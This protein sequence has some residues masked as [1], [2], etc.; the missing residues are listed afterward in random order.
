MD[1]AL[2]AGL[3]AGYGVA[4]PVGAIGALIVGLTAR[5]SLRIGAAAACGVAAADGLY[6]LAAVLGGATL[7]GLLTP[8]ATPLRWVAAAV[9]MALA[10]RTALSAFAEAA[11]RP[12][13]VFTRPSRAF[14]AL[15][16]LTI[17]NPATI[18][19]FAALVLGRQGEA[20]LTGP[21]QA[22]FVVAAF[23]ASLSWQLLLAVFDSARGRPLRNP[24]FVGSGR[25]RAGGGALVGR[26]LTGARGRLVTALAAAAIIAVLAVGLLV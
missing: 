26:T 18:V 19:Y 4:V 7:A 6:A 5:T 13:P 25:P 21:G 14:L 3:L 11:G 12:V 20:A 22:V 9:L 8:V 16:G 2:V 15:L 1:E 10:V 17:L 24:D 23:A